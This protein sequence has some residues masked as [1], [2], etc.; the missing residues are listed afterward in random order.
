M[1]KSVCDVESA[2][3]EILTRVFIL[4]SVEMGGISARYMKGGSAGI[5]QSRE[6][7]LSVSLLKR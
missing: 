5:P 6:N 7:G 4:N 1:K 2:V 3:V